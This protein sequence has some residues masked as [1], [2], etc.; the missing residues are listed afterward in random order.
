M[1]ERR[2]T[3]TEEQL[4]KFWQ[5]ARINALHGPFSGKYGYDKALST[6]A[7]DPVENGAAMGKK[8]ADEFAG[9]VSNN[10]SGPSFISER[11]RK[12]LAKMIDN[13]VTS[14]VARQVEER[15]RGLRHQLDSAVNILEASKCFVM[16]KTSL[17]MADRIVKGGM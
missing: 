14:E 3:V 11:S 10:P 13:S 9:W 5:T 4:A 15:T 12:V 6:L 1:N 2:Y 16:P 8:V 7:A 17:A